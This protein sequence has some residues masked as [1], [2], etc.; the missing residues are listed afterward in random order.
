M[1]IVQPLDIELGDVTEQNILQLKTLNMSYLPVRYTDKFYRD[2]ITNTPK[3]FLKFGNTFSL[4]FFFL[5]DSSFDWK[6]AFWNGFAIGSVCSRLEPHTEKGFHKIY[7][8]TIGVIP[9]Y[10]RRGIGFHLSSSS[11]FYQ[12]FLLIIVIIATKLLEHI[13]ENARRDSTVLEVYLHVQIT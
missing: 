9:A 11:F 5:F 12:F 10:R 1:P 4:L 2:L 13:M 7:I 3:E 8:M 6:I